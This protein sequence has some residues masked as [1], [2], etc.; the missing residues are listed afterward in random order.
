MSTRY[1]LLRTT[2]ILFFSL[3]LG[4]LARAE[5]KAFIG[6]R[7][8]DGTGGAVIDNATLVVQDG[9]VAMVGPSNRGTAPAGAQTIDVRGKT[10]TPGLI[11]AHAH[12]S[13][14]EGRN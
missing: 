6:A 8:F 1:P 4:N 13:D 10:I 3:T 2:A 9:K 14:V 11:D 7:L 12:T 5:T